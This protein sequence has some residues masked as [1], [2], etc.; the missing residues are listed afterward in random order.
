MPLFLNKKKKISLPK[1]E[2]GLT[3]IVAAQPIRN[4]NLA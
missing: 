1:S 4:N 3:H 2:V